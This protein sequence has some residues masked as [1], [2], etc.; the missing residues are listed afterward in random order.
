MDK[1]YLLSLFLTEKGFL[2]KLYKSEESP[3]RLLL[4]ANDKSLNVIIKILHLIA[5]GEIS[6]RSSD[7]SSL[8]KSLRMKK[9]TQFESKT[10][11]LKIL[12]GSREDK[13]KSLNQ[14]ASVFPVLLYSFFNEV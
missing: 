7:A 2:K 4:I 8:K 11:F 14:F 10:Y 5:I 1:V 12:N 6:L 13:I 3:K 9:L